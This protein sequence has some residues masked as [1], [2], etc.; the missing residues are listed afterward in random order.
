M[1]TPTQSSGDVALTTAQDLQQRAKRCTHCYLLTNA[2][3]EGLSRQRCFRPTPDRPAQLPEL[4]GDWTW[5]TDHDDRQPR[6]SEAESGSRST[7]D[8]LVR[9]FA[10]AR[11]LIG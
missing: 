10:W 3:T 1:P 7:K 8:Q 6:P 9:P 11:I 5:Q 4:V 2:A